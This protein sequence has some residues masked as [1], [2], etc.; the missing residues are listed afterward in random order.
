MEE[1][2]SC[3]WKKADAVGEGA[4]SSGKRTRSLQAAPWARFCP[5][6]LGL[7]NPG[8]VLKDADVLLPCLCAT[9]TLMVHVKVAAG[10]FY[11]GNCRRVFDGGFQAAASRVVPSAP[12]Q[13][14]ALFPGCLANPETIQSLI[15]STVINP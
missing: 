14:H 13:L 8:C 12:R 4:S 7:K 15:N 10:W 2:V 1:A 9:R 3:V 11:L 6:C 5:R